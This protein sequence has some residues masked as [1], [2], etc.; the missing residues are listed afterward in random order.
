M[1]EARALAV[2]AIKWLERGLSESDLRQAL[3]TEPPEGGVQLGGRPA[4][5]RRRYAARRG[6]TPSAPST[7]S[8]PARSTVPP[9]LSGPP[10]AQPRHPRRPRF[11]PPPPRRHR[12]RRAAE[13]SPRSAA[14]HPSARCPR[15][16][17]RW[18]LPGV[19]PSQGTATA[20]TRLRSRVRT[21]QCEHGSTVLRS[22]VHVARDEV[23]RY[24][25]EVTCVSDCT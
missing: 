21:P 23:V 17:S 7:A 1:H 24:G 20:L 19:P 16:P 8:D 3:L 25:E 13:T 18:S 14:A 5:L 4:R 11:E 9:A 22:P 12:P 15:R 6:A 2:E 10:R